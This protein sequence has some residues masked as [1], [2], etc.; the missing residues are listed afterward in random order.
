MKKNN[1]T[2]LALSSVALGLHGISTKAATPTAEA[3]GNVQYGYYIEEGDRMQA[4]VYHGDFVVPINDFFEFTFS[5]DWDVYI[6]ATPSH[7]TPQVMAD[8]ITAASG[9]RATPF[10]IAEN[11]FQQPDARNAR[12]SATGTQT[13][14]GIIGLNAVIKR[15]IPDFKPVESFQFQP[16]ENRKMPILGT[17]LYL[18]D[19]TMGLNV[20]QSIEPD[21][22][23]TFGSINLSWELNNKLTTLSAGY[24]LT[25][26]DIT[27]SSGDSGGGGHHGGSDDDDDDKDTEEFRREST[28]HGINLGLSQVMSKHTLFH[29]NGSYTNQAGY[30]SN[31]YKYVY[32]RGEIT[33]QEYLDVLRAG[34]DSQ[35]GFSNATDLETVGPDLFREVRP[36]KR[37]QWTISTGINQHIPA[38]DAS[39]HF[40]YRYYKDSWDISSH[41]FDLS[42]H[43][44]LPFGLTVVPNIRYYS[45]SAADFF[46]PYF[47]TPRADGYYSSDYRLSGFGKL[48]GG[49]SI[50]K[51]FAKG[52]RL[53]AGFEYF[54]HQGSLKL[55]GG[56]VDDYADIDSFLVSG[57]LEVDLSSL[58]GTGSEH[59]HHN[60]R[61][62]G[63]HPPAGVM[64][65]HMLDQAG[66]MM[67]GYHYMYGNSSGSMR[68]GTNSVDDQ[69]LISR[70]CVDL[71][72][73]FKPGEMT[74]HMHMFN[75][76]YAP[77][78]WLNL[79]VMPQ[80]ISMDMDMLPLDSEDEAG[81]HESAGLGDTL[82]VALIKLFDTETHHLHLGLGFSAPTGSIEATFDNTESEESDLQSFGMQLGSGT[83][84]FKP[85]LT[86]TGNTGRW[87]WGA[88]ASATKRM[89]SR[90]KLGYVLGDEIQGS[91]WGG[92][93]VLDWLSFSV[94]NVYK[95]QGSIRGQ[96][97]RVIPPADP[98]VD[99][100]PTPL[101]NPANYGGQFWDIG[102]GVNLSAPNSEFAGH[103]LSIEWLQP[104]IHDF[105]GY[106]LERNGSLSVRWGY[107]F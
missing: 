29:L 55:G 21:F 36:D 4:Q 84:D 1:K 92:Y 106:Q 34:P 83:W 81:G 70:A 56:G 28:F 44:E 20:G 103:S 45:Q 32:V 68:L 75:L 88:Q 14:K 57:S 43:Q 19:V 67:V 52:I 101:E 18:G 62:H 100:E 61:H 77:T 80:L 23:S 86:Y 22:E 50:H 39:L 85:S 91:I 37:H 102:L 42:W 72:C 59:N 69:Q 10:K 73:T 11:I 3:E 76:M 58:S 79:M 24:T 47:L 60:M 17:N 30:L 2:L 35:I 65:G 82:L 97:N 51:Q 27:R 96:I 8:V 16:R 6:G 98:P 74:M 15:P 105:N 107:A 54:S 38:L 31:P 93:R 104:V 66:D 78:D 64:F 5:Y 87:F 7:S 13:E 40:D 95:A 89:Q 63:G 33:G 90:N 41:T 71:D 46:A 12:L 26:N 53:N 94:R 9:S 99:P 25:H 48:G 49:V